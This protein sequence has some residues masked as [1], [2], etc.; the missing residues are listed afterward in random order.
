MTHIRGA[1][2]PKLCSPHSLACKHAPCCPDHVQG[3]L[4]IEAVQSV[5]IEAFE[6]SQ[7]LNFNVKIVLPYMFD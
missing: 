4:D 1:R 5:A 3:V 7:R 2:T 6:M